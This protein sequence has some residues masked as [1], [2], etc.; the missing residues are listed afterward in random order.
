M[1]K[2]LAEFMNVAGK[3]PFEA[4]NKELADSR[5]CD[6]VHFKSEEEKKLFCKLDKSIIYDER[7]RL[8]IGMKHFGYDNAEKLKQLNL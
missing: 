4:T 3:S 5:F 1:G 6:D 8:E 7:K 2:T